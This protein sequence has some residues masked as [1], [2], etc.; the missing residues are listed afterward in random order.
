MANKRGLIYFCIAFDDE[1]TDMKHIN[2]AIL[3][4]TV[5]EAM[6]EVLSNIPAV[7]HFNKLDHVKEI[8][9]D[10]LYGVLF[11]PPIEYISI[12]L[13]L[14]PELQLEEIK[15][16]VTESINEEKDEST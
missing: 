13:V 4:S 6:T 2:E 9:D 3:N 15:D 8:I 14:P 5:P 10:E 12:D 16:I 7:A 11:F 1:E